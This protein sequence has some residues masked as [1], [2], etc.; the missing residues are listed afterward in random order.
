MG[1]G[2]A[3]P[4]LRL[5]H[6]IRRS[7]MSDAQ[8]MSQRLSIQDLMDGR[9]R[10]SITTTSPTTAVVD[11]KGYHG[12]T[13]PDYGYGDARPDLRLQHGGVVETPCPTAPK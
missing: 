1:Y 9:S 7:S 2:D 4:D 13:A 3:K 8:P 5:Q 11:D 10:N 6:D 12:D